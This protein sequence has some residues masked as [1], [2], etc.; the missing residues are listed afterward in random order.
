MGKLFWVSIYVTISVVSK[1]CKQA[2][3]GSFLRPFHPILPQTKAFAAAA[4]AAGAAASAAHKNGPRPSPEKA[5]E[6]A[7]KAVLGEEKSW[8]LAMQLE[9]GKNERPNGP[10]IGDQVFKVL[11]FEGLKCIGLN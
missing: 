3:F 1:V 6:E 4:V 2:S 10:K 9:G 5:A 7:G 8:N 11:F